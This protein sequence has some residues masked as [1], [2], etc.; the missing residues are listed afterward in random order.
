MRSDQDILLDLDGEWARIQG[1][2]QLGTQAVAAQ[3][4]GN[5][6]S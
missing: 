4:T 3:P 1:I 6:K 5:D 2:V